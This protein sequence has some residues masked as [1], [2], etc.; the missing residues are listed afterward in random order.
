MVLLVGVIGPPLIA[1]DIRSRAY[2]LYFSRPIERLDYVIGKS[3]VVWFYL[4]AITALPAFLLYAVAVGMSP[5]MSVVAYT[6]DLPLRVLGASAWLIVPTT[7]LALCYSSLTSESR[8]A[9]YAW[10][11]T[12]AMGWVAYA[13]LRLIP[14]TSRDTPWSLVSL[15]HS[16]GRVQEWVFGLEKDYVDVLPAMIVLVVLTCLALLILFRRVAAPLRI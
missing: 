7:A 10:F 16:L 15:Y 2:L 13:S 5:D 14:M 8:Y 9:G 1:N 4:L 6:W 12:W 3:V 11:A